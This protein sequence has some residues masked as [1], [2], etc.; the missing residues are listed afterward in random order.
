M[1]L[2]Y[3]TNILTWN[4]SSDQWELS[5]QVTAN[6]KGVSEFPFVVERFISE[7]DLLN[8]GAVKPLEDITT[9]IINSGKYLFRRVVTLTDLL[10]LPTSAELAEEL[11]AKQAGRME[12]TDTQEGANGLSVEDNDYSYTDYDYPDP[13][14]A[15]DHYDHIPVAGYYTYRVES[16]SASYSTYDLA[17][18]VQEANDTYLR[19]YAGDFLEDIAA[20]F[21][22]LS[23]GVAGVYPPRTFTPGSLQA[24][25][26]VAGD[27]IYLSVSGGSGDYT[28]D[29]DKGALLETLSA[30]KRYK[31]VS[32]TNDTVTITV[33]DA[34]TLESKDVVLTIVQKGD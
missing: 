13:L 18:A 30:T 31:V 16:M 25:D 2:V 12:S 19:S 33:R 32:N 26:L 21:I 4:D 24:S 1:A 17:S 7:E 3:A 22:P 15:D 9:E 14:T 11:R 10:S 5:M 8:G 34:N 27:S 29:I 6:Q 20:E 28:A 23:V